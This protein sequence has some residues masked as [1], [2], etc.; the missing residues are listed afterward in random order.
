MQTQ[1]GLLLAIYF[2]LYFLKYIKF[3]LQFFLKRINVFYCGLVSVEEAASF[4]FLRK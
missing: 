1:N 3:F 4:S 2:V